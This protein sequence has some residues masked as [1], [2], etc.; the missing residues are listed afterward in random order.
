MGQDA[1]LSTDERRAFLA[2]R[3]ATEHQIRGIASSLLRQIEEVQ[4]S[5]A[6]G[7]LARSIQSRRAWIS[8]TRFA[9][10]WLTYF[11]Q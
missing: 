3:H 5:T 11:V 10:W 2:R 4:L 8:S 1:D 6:S 7:T 9:P